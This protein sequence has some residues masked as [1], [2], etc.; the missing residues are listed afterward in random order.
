MCFAPSICP[1]ARRVKRIERPERGAGAGAETGRLPAPRRPMP[2]AAAARQSKPEAHCL[3]A[4]M[5]FGMLV[6]AMA[7]EQPPQQQAKL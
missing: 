7:P 5:Y 1:A 3:K 4:P 6:A 2:L